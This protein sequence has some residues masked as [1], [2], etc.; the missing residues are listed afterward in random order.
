[1][2]TTELRLVA[3]LLAL[4]VIDAAGWAG[5]GGGGGGTAPHAAS[6]SS[7]GG[8]PVPVG[9]LSTGAAQAGAVLRSKGNAVATFSIPAR[10]TWTVT[11]NV[12]SSVLSSTSR[13]TL[14]AITIPAEMSTRGHRLRVLLFGSNNVTASVSNSLNL[15]L[16]GALIGSSI[17]N[18]TFSTVNRCWFFA[19]QIHF[20]EA[21]NPATLYTISGIGNPTVHPC[22]H[23]SRPDPPLNYKFTHG[24]GTP[25]VA[26]L[27]EITMLGGNSNPGNVINIERVAYVYD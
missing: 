15:H 25:G 27:L 20:L 12:S 5:G 24:M 3:V 17:F 13:V 18:L 7:G 9:D 6:H 23:S 21:G 4:A 8:D 26:K 2:R 14:S 19:A 22:T 16:D 1:M 11:T 10:N